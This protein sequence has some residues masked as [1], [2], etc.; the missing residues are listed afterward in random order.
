M[1]MK[2]LKIPN[3]L[4]GHIPLSSVMSDRAKGSLREKVYSSLRTAILSGT[5]QPQ[6]RLLEQSLARNLGVSRTPI[7][8]SLQK[9][10]KEGLIEYFPNRG[11]RLPR[12]R[13]AYTDETFEIRAILEGYILRIACE[14]ATDEFLS[15]LKSLV[16]RAQLC[17]IQSNIRELWRLNTLFHD[18]I[19]QQ[20]PGRD[21]L[22]GLIK[23]LRE[24]ILYFRSATLRAPGGAERALEDHEKIILALETR[25]P[26]L[27]EHIMRNHIERAKLDATRELTEDEVKLS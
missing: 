3:K 25:D 26:A 7:R 4:N 2:K 15:D 5:F 17:L 23:D 13:E 18:R 9:L 22:K 12:D 6:S 20:V 10:E 11:F 16:R 14:I 21:R 24:Y 8:E 19:I 27:C 1:V